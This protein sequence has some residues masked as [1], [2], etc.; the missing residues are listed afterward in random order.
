[1][2]VEN[3]TSFLADKNRAPSTSEAKKDRIHLLGE[4]KE[5]IKDYRV[6]DCFAYELSFGGRPYI[7]C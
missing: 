1:M 3:W 6:Y 4:G 5:E 7:L 2:R